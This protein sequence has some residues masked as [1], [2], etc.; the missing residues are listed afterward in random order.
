[1]NYC[2]MTPLFLLERGVVGCQ[3]KA[4]MMHA[5]R[6]AKKVD[7]ETKVCNYQQGIL[8][9][10]GTQEHKTQSNHHLYVGKGLFFLQSIFQL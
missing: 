2:N 3:K 6:S 8:T 9:K 7:W 5:M 4:M 10:H 1:M